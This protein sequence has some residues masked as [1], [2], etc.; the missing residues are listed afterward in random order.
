MSVEAKHSGAW[1]NLTGI[2]V[3][4]SGAWRDIKTV[5]VKHGGV[6]R[7]VYSGETLALP[8]TILSTGNDVS[9]PYY[10]AAGVKVDTDGYMYRLVTNGSWSQVSGADYWINNKSATMS[11]YECQLVRTS[12]V[13]SA[14][15]YGLNL[16]T[17]YTLSVDRAWGISR[18]SQGNSSFAGTL[19]I[20][21]IANPSNVV[22][23]GV[24][25]YAE[26]GFL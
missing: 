22:T 3:K 14:N 24:T 20:R 25:M 17:W 23:C 9:S 2:E 10:A 21:E 13:A 26:A 5:E 15:L 11:N 12:G 6:W 4:H 8:T 19:Y 7:T 18:S 1:R 16:S